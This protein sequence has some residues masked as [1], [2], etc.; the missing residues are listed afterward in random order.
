MIR[1]RLLLL[2]D[3]RRGRPGGHFLDRR[4]P[5]QSGHVPDQING[6]PPIDLRQPM[7]ELV[8]AQL[9][10]A[11]IEIEI[12]QTPELGTYT[13]RLENGAGDIFLE[14]VSQNDANPAFFGRSFFYSRS[15]GPYARWFAAGPEFDRKL[16]QALASTDR[17]QAIGAA[18]QAMQVAVG[19]QVVVLPVAATN[20][21]F[22]MSAD[23][24][25]FVLHGSARHVR[26]DT[27]RRTS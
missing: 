21:L 23:V 2:A 16:E 17:E 8:Q 4:R 19:K 11:G 6:Y 25:G 5:C 22:A 13:D 14:R 3:A 1:M 15:D 24:D 20:W 26:W 7:P 9:R 12:V 18:A 27:V 10:E